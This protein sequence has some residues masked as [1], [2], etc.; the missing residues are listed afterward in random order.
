VSVGVQAAVTGELPTAQDAGVAIATGAAVGA[1]AAHGTQRATSD[2]PPEKQQ[3]LVK[4]RPGPEMVARL[5]A[6]G[7]E[8]IVNIGGTGA[9]HEPRDAINLNPNDIPGTERKNIPNLIQAKGETIGS[10]FDPESV[11][12]VVGNRL[13]PDTFDWD[14]VAQG[15]IKVMKPGAT[16]DINV[17]Y[18]PQDAMRLDAALRNAGFSRVETFSVRV[19]AVKPIVQGVKP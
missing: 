13:P 6:E 15:A 1:A 3:T 9:P 12:R 5:R 19:Q 17:A 10:E 7:K 8:V 4:N 14:Q 11:D 18:S 2:V 16:I